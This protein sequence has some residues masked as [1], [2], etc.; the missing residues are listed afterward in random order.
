MTL[1]AIVAEERDELGIGAPTSP[2]A[3]PLYGLAGEVVDL[4]APYTEADHVAVGLTFLVAFGALV[5]PGPRMMVGAEPH[6]P[7]ENLVLVGKSA[8]ARKGSSWAPVREL[9]RIADPAL[10][11]RTLSGLGSGEGLIARLAPSA[12]EGAAPPDPR[13]LVYEPEFARILRVTQREKSTLS[14]IL[15]EAWDRGDLAVITRQQPLRVTGAHVAIIAHIT[16]DELRKELHD[17]EALNGFGNRF[18]WLPVARSRLIPEPAP[19]IGP[20]IEQMGRRI[21]HRLEEARRHEIV[22]RTPAASRRWKEIYTAL[23]DDDR[24]GLLGALTSRAEAHVLRLSL[25]YAL[26]DGTGAVDLPHLDAALATWEYLMA[27]ATRMFGTATGDRIED[28]LLA[29]LRRRGSMTRSEIRMLFSGHP[30]AARIEVALERLHAAGRIVPS[31][32]ATGGR[33]SEVWTYRAESA[34]SAR[35]TLSTLSTLSAHRGTETT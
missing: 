8:K 30:S 3:L 11:D 21:R 35:T 28:G 27:G 31:R 17:T 34:E 26:T 32:E 10:P 33:P 2:P 18:L 13:A 5:G 1:S 16:D 22:Q 23:A 14:P 7:R 12:E 20:E 24:P 25:I 19:F 9:L 6:P 4:A 29:E 15:R